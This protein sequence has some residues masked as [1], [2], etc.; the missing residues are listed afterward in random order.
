MPAF[1]N[2]QSVRKVGTWFC[3]LVAVAPA[4]LPK[5]AGGF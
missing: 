2:I 4:L 1:E 3:L 5:T